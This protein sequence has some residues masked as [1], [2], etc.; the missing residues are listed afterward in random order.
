MIETK[1]I[2]K[3]GDIYS[4]FKQKSKPDTDMP[5]VKLFAHPWLNRVPCW[6]NCWWYVVGLTEIVE[7]QCSKF[8]ITWKNV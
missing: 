1:L 4:V 6:R 5:L 2:N 7:K 3:N 8:Y